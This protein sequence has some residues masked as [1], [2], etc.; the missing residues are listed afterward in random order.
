MLPTA[1]GLFREAAEEVSAG[2]REKLLTASCDGLFHAD[3]CS[4]NSACRSAGWAF[5]A[6]RSPA[7]RGAH[8]AKPP[9]IA[10]QIPGGPLSSGGVTIPS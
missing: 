2:P 5:A 8:T 3:K 9:G 1:Q 6:S 10:A 4:Y 7:L